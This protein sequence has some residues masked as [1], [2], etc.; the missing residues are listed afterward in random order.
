MRNMRNV[1]LENEREKKR[2]QLFNFVVVLWQSNLWRILKKYTS[3][4]GWSKKFLIFPFDSLS[5]IFVIM[6]LDLHPFAVVVVSCSLLSRQY[7][8]DSRGNLLQFLCVFHWAICNFVSHIVA[9][10]KIFEIP[11]SFQMKCSDEKFAV[12]YES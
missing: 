3:P 2:F 1:S 4:H 12:C 7:V 10:R 5:F 8:E 11:S 9:Q 6:I